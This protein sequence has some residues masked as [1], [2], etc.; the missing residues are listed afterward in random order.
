MM[1]YKEE[2]F[3]QLSGI[4]HFVFCR[5]QWAL[6]YI[7]QI[8]DENARTM[9]GRL[10]HERA[11]DAKQTEVRKNVIIT[12]AM[13]VYSKR[14]GVNGMCD[15]VEFHRDDVKGV[16]IFGREGRYIPIPIEYKRG[17][18]KS[19]DADILQLT[20]QAMCLEE[21]LCC[22]IEYGYIYYGEPR[23]RE[24]VKFTME[25]RDKVIKIF[26]EMHL[27]FKKGYIPKVKTSRS[28]YACSIKNHC[29]PKLCKNLSVEKYLEKMME[30]CE[31]Y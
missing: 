14:L 31:N 15:V 3:L 12:R 11:H 7:D 24:I 29:I 28:C 19:H 4:Q 23:R 6:I 2:E 30:E 27:Y 13:P 26:E 16:T 10:M 17:K 8:W 1:E 22:D 5:R 25:Y 20:A 21:M 9:E 18:A